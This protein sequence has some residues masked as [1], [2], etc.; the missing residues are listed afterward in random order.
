MNFNTSPPKACTAP[1]DAV[2]AGIEGGDHRRR[3]GRLGQRG[4]VAQIGAE[5]RGADGLAGAAAQR[6]GLH[7]G[8]TA[9]AEIGFEQRRQRRPRGES[10]QGRSGENLTLDPRLRERLSTETDRWC[11]G[12]ETASSTLRGSS[13]WIGLTDGS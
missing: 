3:L 5:Q 9:P 8:G 1:R 6:T 10:G 13:T 2:E 12:E 11:H 7:P 4:E